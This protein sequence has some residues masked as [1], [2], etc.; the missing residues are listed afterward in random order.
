MRAAATAKDAEDDESEAFSK[1]LDKWSSYTRG[2]WRYEDRPR[3]RDLT[4]SVVSD[5]DRLSAGLSADMAVLVDA[6]K[7]LLAMTMYMTN[8]GSHGT[9][10]V[11]P[12]AV[13]AEDC[14][15][16]KRNTQEK[17]GRHAQ[18]RVQQEHEREQ[19]AEVLHYVE[20]AA[21][22]VVP[23]YLGEDTFLT[24]APYDEGGGDENEDRINEADGAAEVVDREEPYGGGG[25]S[26]G[27][28]GG[29]SSSMLQIVKRHNSFRL[30]KQALLQKPSP[31]PSSSSS[32]VA[33]ATVDPEPQPVV[34]PTA[35][36]QSLQDSLSELVVSVDRPAS[37]ASR[38][39]TSSQPKQQQRDDYVAQQPT[40]DQLRYHEQQ[41]RMLLL[42][43]QQ[44]LRPL[45]RTR[46]RARS[47]RAK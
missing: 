10:T 2:N 14:M 3:H 45:L 37:A 25:V 23:T 40:A 44:Q 35:A 41:Q 32:I 9:H 33:P 4:I 1:R 20:S 29:H 31:T 6:E 34:A 27:D 13:S 43:H 46:V 39:T 24:A 22:I 47:S 19:Q 17:L 30:R 8:N 5:S 38:A 16:L 18:Q 21:P 11:R 42:Q 7:S 26:G 15:R 36:T 28:G 12:I